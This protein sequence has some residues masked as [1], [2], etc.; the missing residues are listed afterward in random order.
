[1]TALGFITFLQ[2]GRREGFWFLILFIM[3]LLMFGLVLN[4]KGYLGA[5]LVSPDSLIYVHLP[6]FTSTPHYIFDV[7]ILEMMI[8]SDTCGD[9]IVTLPAMTIVRSGAGGA[10]G[11]EGAAPCRSYELRIQAEPCGEADEEEEKEGGQAGQEG[12]EGQS[13]GVGEGGSTVVHGSLQ[14]EVELSNAV[15]GVVLEMVGGDEGTADQGLPSLQG[16]FIFIYF[17]LYSVIF[18]VKVS[19]N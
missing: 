19:L 2:S 14:C 12:K 9:G 18:S 16:M 3:H 17:S 15:V 5:F 4:Q 13:G 11:E 8:V 7:L 1:M 10:G 6:L